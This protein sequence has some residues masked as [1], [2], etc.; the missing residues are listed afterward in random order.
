MSRS[1]AAV[2]TTAP[3]YTEFDGSTKLGAVD[4]NQSF[5]VTQSQG[6][7]NQG[8]YGGVGWLDLGTVSVKSGTFSVVLSNLASR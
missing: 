5:L 7:L 1:P 3:P 4:I 8:S 6:G 2:V